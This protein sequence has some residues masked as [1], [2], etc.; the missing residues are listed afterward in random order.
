M[1]E[2]R[3]IKMNK[4]KIILF[5]GPDKVGKSSI[6]KELSKVLDIP[7]FKFTKHDYWAKKEY[8]LATKFDQPFLAELLRMTGY[9]LIIDRG[10]PS[11]YAYAPVF[12]RELDEKLILD[13]DDMFSK[14]NTTIVIC[15]KGNIVEHDEKAP[16]E[17][18]DKLIER[19]K[20]FYNNTKCNKIYLET[21][22]VDLDKQIKTITERLSEIYSEQDK[23][24]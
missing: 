13:L 20:D 19:Y 12:D 18:Q 3:L 16:I 8:E 24:G 23:E 2:Q 15:T 7:Y 4:Q 6:A 21:S 22:L 11:E 14:L 1:V 5:D 17:K 10:Y 9:S